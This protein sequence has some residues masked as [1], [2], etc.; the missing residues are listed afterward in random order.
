MHTMQTGNQPET[1]LCKTL[2][3]LSE[4]IFLAHYC[5]VFSLASALK[6][7]GNEA[8]IMET[9]VVS[10]N[11]ELCKS[12]INSRNRLHLWLGSELCGSTPLDNLYTFLLGPGHSPH[13][14]QLDS[15]AG[16]PGQNCVQQPLVWAGE[17]KVSM[18]F[19]PYENHHQLVIK[20][21]VTS[22]KYIWMMWRHDTLK[23]TY[24]AHRAKVPKWLP[25]D[26]QMV[27]TR[28]NKAIP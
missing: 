15:V 24:G 5:Q 22:F 19:I 25:L 3:V 4:L 26:Q 6:G 16:E 27:P 13:L 2:H 18:A 9:R 8:K 12:H 21:V 11:W 7:E 28:Q 10:N 20:H 1:G 23:L 14:E 17:E